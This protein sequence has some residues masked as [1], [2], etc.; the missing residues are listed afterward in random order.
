MDPIMSILLMSIGSICA[1]SFYVP[2]KKIKGWSWESYWLVQGIFSWI[3]VPIL[4]AWLTVPSGTLG[5][6]ISEA[7]SSSKWMAV[8]YGA[9]WGVG[10]LTFGLTMRYL[11]VA[12]GQSIALGLCA[13]IGTILPPII[14][15]NNLF[16]SRAG[17]LILIGVTVSIV[18]ISIIGYAG[19]LKSKNMSE[20]DKKAAVKDFALKKGILIA[21]LSGVMSACFNFGLTAGEPIR[22]AALANGT[23][24][25]FAKNPV[26]MFVTLGGFFTNLIYCVFLNVKNKSYKDYLSVSGSVLFNNIFFAM[27]GGTLWYMQFFFMG[28]GE[29]K[30]PAAM[31]AFSWS[32]LMSMNITFSNIWGILLK[33]WKG[34]GRKT[35]T[36]LVI[37][38]VVLVLSTFV[39]KL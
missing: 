14:S 6:I 27:L 20:E 39:I 34:A 24:A 4:F 15:G 11:G 31:M 17:I 22:Q 8:F 13:A 33:E 37:G 23:N 16:A 36:V 9:L 32:I 7:P 38:L 18:G 29:S 10:G 3:I 1:A 2:I 21:I 25:L 5:T 19:S 30:L 12:L 26:I 28:M 35:I